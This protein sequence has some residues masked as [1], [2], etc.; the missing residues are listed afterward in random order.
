MTESKMV[1]RLS[2]LTDQQL[3]CNPIK[4]ASH[5]EAFFMWFLFNFKD[6]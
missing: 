2:R 4:N 5:S 6:S 1:Q 3:S